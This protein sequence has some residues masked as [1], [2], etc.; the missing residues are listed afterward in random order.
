MA[1]NGLI[2]TDIKT[3]DINCLF[4]D[5]SYESSDSY[6][7]KLSNAIKAEKELTIEKCASIPSRIF[8]KQY[9]V[10]VEDIRLPNNCF[11]SLT[12]QQVAHFKEIAILF[13]DK[14]IVSLKKKESKPILLIQNIATPEIASR[15]CKWICNNFELNCHFHNQEFNHISVQSKLE[16]LLNASKEVHIS[17]GEFYSRERQKAKLAG[18]RE[19]GAVDILTRWQIV[20]IKPTTQWE[21]AIDQLDKYKRY[22]SQKTRVV[23]LYDWGYDSKSF[24]DNLME[25]CSDLGIKVVFEF[26]RDQYNGNYSAMGLDCHLYQHSHLSMSNSMSDFLAKYFQ[27]DNNG[28]CTWVVK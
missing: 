2:M 5:L 12:P 10:V 16:Y 18:K 21:S 8:S 4:K 26:L 19:N 25:K 28:N 15:I 22:F 13:R 1:T 7:A 20:E 24:R 3:F 11:N 6:L 27:Y 14:F 23:Y 9:T 17:K